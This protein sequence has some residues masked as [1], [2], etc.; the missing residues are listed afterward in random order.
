MIYYYCTCIADKVFRK[1]IHKNMLKFR[2][3]QAD[4]DGVC[5]ECGHYAVASPK[6]IT[7]FNG[8][9]YRTV[10]DTHQNAAEK[11]GYVN[12]H[13]YKDKNNKGRYEKKRREDKDGDMDI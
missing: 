1:N 8:E 6:K 7:I 4:D 11:R 9:L 2:E 10:T 12:T 13:L 5:L 3:V